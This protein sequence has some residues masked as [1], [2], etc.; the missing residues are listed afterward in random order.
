MKGA[1]MSVSVKQLLKRRG[2][3]KTFYDELKNLAQVE[4]SR[5]GYF[6]NFIVNILGHWPYTAVSRKSSVSM[7]KE[8]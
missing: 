5:H 6:D 2:I 7:F 4:H 3:I 1:L 8:H